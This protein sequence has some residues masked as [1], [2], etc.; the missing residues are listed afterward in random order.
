[1]VR[2]VHER[3]PVILERQGIDAWLGD[4]ADTGLLKA[5]LVPYAGAALQCWA[6]SWKV[7]SPAHDAPEL[8]EPVTAP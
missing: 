2:P 4:T 6:V 3:M 1:M 8:L 5:L 7:N